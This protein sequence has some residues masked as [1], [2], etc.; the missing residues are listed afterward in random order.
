MPATAPT[1]FDAFGAAR[2]LEAAGVE[3]AQAEAIAGAVA[4]QSVTR[5]DLETLATKGEVAALRSEVRWML[6]FHAALTLAIAARLFG[7]V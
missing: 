6:G 5:S 2:A 1:A 4:A 7:V 3:R